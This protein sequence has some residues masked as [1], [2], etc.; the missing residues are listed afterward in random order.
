MNIA[1]KYDN[2]EQYIQNDGVVYILGPN[3]SGKT[4]LL[5]LLKEGFYGKNQ[6]F[7]VDNI[8][9]NKN[10]FKIIFFDDTTDFNGEF[11]FTKTNIFRELIYSNVLKKIN[12]TKLLKDVNDLF[13]EIDS[14]VNNFLDLNI[15]KKQEEKINFDIEINDVNEIIDKF[16]NI[17]V[18]NYLLKDSN[19]PRSTKR[20][21]IYN[22][23]LFELNKSKERTNVVF[24]D[25]FDLYLDIENTKKVINMLEKYSRNNN[26]FF[27]L[28][29]SN[30]IYSFIRDKSNIYHI[31]KKNISHV[32]DL[33]SIVQKAILKYQYSKSNTK[34]NL[35]EFI[36]QNTELF[37]NDIDDKYNEILCRY[38]Q[39]I[40]KIYIS[41]KI[42]LVDKYDPKY[43]DI[44]IYCKSQ[45][46]QY[47]FAELYNK[48]NNSS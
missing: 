9:V 25:N 5:N 38:Q 1:Y 6:E 8:L 48:L 23:L 24:I 37:R 46:D 22:L 30:N 11:K 26:T 2:K 15:N 18:D 42:R 33:K 45:S 4:F 36:N 41:N 44:I 10:D 39:E 7:I 20:K 47:F 28:S 16:T 43:D 19:I 31:S 12:D 3:Q 40:G 21:L 27:F 32:K 13:D 35:E 29:T 17:Y 14:K 34:T